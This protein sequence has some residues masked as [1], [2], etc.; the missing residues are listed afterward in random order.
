[1]Q[2]EVIMQLDPKFFS[3]D[4]MLQKRLFEI[5][6]YQRAY[7]WTTKQRKDLFNDIEKLYNYE[8]YKNGRTHF[9]ATVVCHDKNRVEEYE[10]DL[11]RVLDIVDGQQR[12][13][14]LII[15][16]K[17]IHKKLY[18]IQ[19][20][21]YRRTVTSLDELLVKD[22]NNR[23]ILIQTNHSSSLILRDYLIDGKHPNDN[24]VNTLAAKNLKKAFE[25]CEKF[26]EEWHN[27]YNI[28]E[29]LI[30]LKSKLYFILHIIDDE[31]AVYTVFEV[32]NSRGLEVDW[33]D[34]CKSILMGIAFEKL[35]GKSVNFNS[36]LEWLHKY[37]SQIYEAIGV[38][39][40]N[41]G[42]IVKFT[43]T[44]YHPDKHSRPLKEEDAIEFF[45]NICTFNPEKVVEVSKW[46]LDVTIELKEILTNPRLEAVSL[47][48]HARLAAVAIK[49]SEHFDESQS[50]ILMDQ[51]ERVTFRVFG[52]FQKDS[53]NKVGEYTKLSNFIMG[54]NDIKKIVIDKNYRFKKSM[55]EMQNIGEDFP[56]D[57]M[58]KELS[59]KDCYN[60]WGKELK[61]F[62]YRYEEYLSEKKGY[63]F[64]VK[65]WESIWRSST[66]ETIEHIY[67][68]NE[69]AAWKGKV[70]KRKEF[71]SNKLG[72]LLILPRKLN[73]RIKN[74]GFIDKKLEY[75]NTE[76]LSTKEILDYDDWD[77]RT[78][79]ERTIELL[80]WAAV[81][82]DNISIEE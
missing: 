52:L 40:I 3:F 69:S 6:E 50:K 79:E 1:L 14:T 63:S 74:N 70:T 62:F 17:A 46:I 44:L 37:W 58:I 71:H 11:F 36:N 27:N 33:L 59:E 76:M 29:L 13:T 47:I 24:K 54:I 49:L 15:L 28:V 51:W 60:S 43:A 61:Y 32:L 34:K 30:L 75:V 55:K 73:S 67:P 10:T 48:S 57:L 78:I 23:L 64:P 38:T 16:L 21:K 82:W 26:V 68:Q 80:K 5:P 9:M 8:D 72:N 66:N 25:E 18:Q 22:D 19:D 81:R 45:R 56:M 31:G 4:E 41:G 12:I 65:T 39:N 53:R 20:P 77:I 2:G 42:D 7:S 35:K